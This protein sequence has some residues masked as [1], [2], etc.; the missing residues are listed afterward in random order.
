MNYQ[1][2]SAATGLV[3]VEID[4]SGVE[5]GRTYTDKATGA[6]KP[7]PGRQTGYVWQGG[8]YPVEVAIDIPEGK[9]PYAPGFYFFG[10]TIF[11][12]GDYG[13]LT[14]KGSREVKLVQVD[15]LVDRLALAAP[16]AVKAA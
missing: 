5:Q 16:K 7:L 1:E 3:L 2:L 10:G 6:Q 4:G 8:R 15:E 14:F 13:R 12:S 9:G 11:Q